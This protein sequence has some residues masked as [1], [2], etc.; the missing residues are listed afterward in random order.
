[1]IVNQNLILLVDDEADILDFVGYNLEKN[2][3]EVITATS[4]P[5]AIEKATE[6]LPGLIILDVMMP[7]MDGIEACEE[8]RKIPEIKETIIAMLSAR[9]EDY[10]Q[11]AGFEAGADDYIKKPIRPNVLVMRVKA[12][13][14]RLK[15]E[16]M[17]QNL[18]RYKDFS[19]DKEK[20]LLIR[21]DKE[22]MLPKKEF[23]LLLLL[24]SKPNKVFTRE[25]ILRAIWGDEIV[26]G[27]RTIDVHIR[28]IRE[29]IGIDYIKTFK[30][31]GYS[32]C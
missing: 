2:G 12:L 30:G 28:K 10:S 26:V 32:F 24:T 7:G 5:E 19:I 9:G 8:L 11:L 25:E 17:H 31:V 20:Y 22:M 23:E 6:Y 1:M 21:K 4:G 29:K 15:E 3:F 16:T 27:D 13:I 18:L 14:R